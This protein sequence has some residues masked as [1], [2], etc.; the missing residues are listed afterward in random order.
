MLLEQDV[1]KSEVDTQARLVEAVARHLSGGED[2]LDANQRAERVHLKLEQDRLKLEQDR[3]QL[4]IA[5]SQL[6]RSREDII[7]ARTER[8]LN[9]LKRY[10][11]MGFSLEDAKKEVEEQ[12]KIIRSKFWLVP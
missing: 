6:A 10:K 12:E 2:G 4:E 11:D 1:R 9:M 7:D 8:R 5:R 3:L